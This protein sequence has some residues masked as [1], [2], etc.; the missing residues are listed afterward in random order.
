[1]STYEQERNSSSKATIK[2][3]NDEGLAPRERRK[4]EKAEA[5]S[6]KAAEEQR[7]AGKAD[8]RAKAK[9]KIQTKV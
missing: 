4:L 8:R 1:M 3:E 5:G 7:A 9:F 6:G 2:S